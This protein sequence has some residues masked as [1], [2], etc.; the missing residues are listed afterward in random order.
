MNGRPMGH[1]E[2]GRGGEE[3]ERMHVNAWRYEGWSGLEKSCHYCWN[4]APLSPVR[5]IGVGTV[6]LRQTFLLSLFTLLTLTCN[7][8][9]CQMKQLC[10]CYQDIIYYTQNHIP[11]NST[12]LFILALLFTPL[13]EI[14]LAVNCLA[15]CLSV[16]DLQ[17]GLGYNLN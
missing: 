14:S 16:P 5:H 3:P 15:A 9:A 8:R 1:G 7:M 10:Y 12:N 11:L 13:R 4:D 6:S 2:G 17:I